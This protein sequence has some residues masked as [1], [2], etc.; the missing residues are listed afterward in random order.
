[1]HVIQ[2]RSSCRSDAARR[3]SNMCY[4]PL[5][6]R[7]LCLLLVSMSIITSIIPAEAAEYKPLMQDLLTAKIYNVYENGVFISDSLETARYFHQVDSAGWQWECYEDLVFSYG[8]ITFRAMRQPDK[9][10]VKYYSGAT[11]REAEFVGV[12]RDLYQYKVPIGTNLAMITLEAFWNT[13]YTGQFTLYSFTAIRDVSDPISQLDIKDKLWYI[14]ETSISLEDD[15]EKNV[16]GVYFPNWSSGNRY[17]TEGKEYSYVEVSLDVRPS[18]REYDLCNSISFLLQGALDFNNFGV[19][20]MDSSYTPVAVLD[21]SSIVTV[22]NTVDIAG[23]NTWPMCLTQVDVDL[24][25]YDLKDYIIR[26]NF[27][28]ELVSG[29]IG[30]EEYFYQVLS[31]SM[32]PRVESIPWYKTF[33]NWL[34]TNWERVTGKITNSISSAAEKI[35][36]AFAG[37][38]AQNEALNQAGQAMSDQADSMNQA[39]DE[40]NSVDKPSLSP[41]NLFGDIL[42]FDTGGLRVLSAITSNSQVTAMLV[43]VFTFALC[44]YIFFGKKG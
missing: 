2:N 11:P 13:S 36:A 9:V 16:T 26:L 31:C 22:S 38:S 32:E 5:Y 19:Q 24:S 17:S 7:L 29:G 21:S 35:S 44:G 23:P 39:Q 28:L 40:L 27:E 10:T 3:Q 25:G 33:W 43:V 20:L 4:K 37:S 34:F 41:D 1:M 42:V 8:Y 14:N 18:Y 30:Y 6:A 12:T 15:I